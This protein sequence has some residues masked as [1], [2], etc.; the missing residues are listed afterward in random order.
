MFLLIT[1]YKLLYTSMLYPLTFIAP[2]DATSHLTPT[3][4]TGSASEVIKSQQS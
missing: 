2:L 3:T 4:I 1:L